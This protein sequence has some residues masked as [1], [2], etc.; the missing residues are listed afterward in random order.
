MRI[1]SDPNDPG[2]RQYLA[3]EETGRWPLI[4]LDGIKM[5]D[6]LT[7]DSDKGFLTRAVVDNGGIIAVDETGE[8][9]YQWPPDPA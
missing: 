6:V 4:F 3:C 9:E 8:I 2:Y 1:S 5:M 7:A